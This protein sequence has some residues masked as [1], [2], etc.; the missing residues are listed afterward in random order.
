MVHSS[1]GFSSFNDHGNWLSSDAFTDIV[2]LRDNLR[3]H[4][5]FIAKFF[6]IERFVS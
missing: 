3:N 1:F 6:H 5:S 2:D 4:V